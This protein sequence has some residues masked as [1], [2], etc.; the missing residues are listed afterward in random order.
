MLAQAGIQKVTAKSETLLLAGKARSKSRAQPVDFEEE[1]QVKT[2]R[3]CTR[4]SDSRGG[5]VKG[6]E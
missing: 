3:F 5:I 1:R 6:D 4:L 2:D